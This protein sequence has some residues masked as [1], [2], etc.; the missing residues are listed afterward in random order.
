MGP[1]LV[2]MSSGYAPITYSDKDESKFLLLA[3]S[4]PTQGPFCQYTSLAYHIPGSSLIV[5]KREEPKTRF[6]RIL[7]GLLSRAAVSRWYRLSSLRVERNAWRATRQGRF[8]GLVHFL[9][10]ERD[11]GFFDILPSSRNVALCATFHSCPDTLPVVIAKSSRLS[12]LSAVILMSELQRPYFLSRGVPP[13]RIHVVHHG[14]DCRFFHPRQSKLEDKF[15]VL[16]VGGY[17]RNF[18]LLRDLCARLSWNREIGFKIVGP[19]T[20]KAQF[21]GLPNVEFFTEV[22]ENDLVRLYQSSSCFVMAI[23][24]A[25]ANNAILEAMA[26]GLPIVSENISAIREYTGS[27][28]ALL[29]QPRSV[30]ALTKGIL[31]LHERPD[32]R[33]RMG[34]LARKRAEGLDWHIVAGKTVRVYERVLTEFESTKRPSC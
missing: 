26:C 4:N 28:C 11:W 32:L 15:T 12:R 6:D 5:Q 31:R 13:N 9:W 30:E 1:D 8:S 20:S 23:D 29:C 3:S 14:V 19:R 21:D 16:T 33:L 7:T 10:A 27:D 34:V 24:A 17:R 22:G 25:T 18:S 2:Q